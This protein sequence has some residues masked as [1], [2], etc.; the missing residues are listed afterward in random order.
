MNFAFKVLFEVRIVAISIPLI[1]TVPLAVFTHSYWALIIGTI[2]V[3]V[4][5]GIILSVRS[6]WK[7][8]LY[9]SVEKFK[10]MFSFS[11][12][13]LVEQIAI[14]LTSYIDTFIVGTLLNTYYVGIYKTSTTTVNQIMTL[15]TS[16]TTPVLFSALSRVQTSEAE[17]KKIF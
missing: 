5:Q 17:F 12:W 15:I 1:V 9:Y 6:E 11:F 4:A 7:P 16:A 14:W 2:A 3:N 13:T 8:R 10:E